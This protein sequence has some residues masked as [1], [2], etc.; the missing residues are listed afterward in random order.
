MKPL[1]QLRFH[2]GTKHE[3]YLALWFCY[4]GINQIQQGCIPLQPSHSQ[5]RLGKKKSSIPKNLVNIL[6]ILDRVNG[7]Q[8]QAI[9]V[10]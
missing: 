2:L 10:F 5:N 1:H 7:T 8:K 3:I 6:S 4:L 9:L